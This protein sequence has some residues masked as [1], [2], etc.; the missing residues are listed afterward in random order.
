MIRVLSIHPYPSFGGPH[1]EAL[2]V[3]GYLRE[4]G[5]ET[6]LVLPEEPGTAYEQVS[7][8]MPVRRLKLGR[9]RGTLRPSVHLRTALSLGPD[10][11]RLRGLVRQERPD[12]VRVHGS[13]NPQG[14]FA[15][16]LEGVPVVWVVSNGLATV[17]RPLRAVGGMLV[18]TLAS[19][20]LLNGRL[21]AQFFPFLDLVKQRWHVYYPPVDMTRFCRFPESQLSARAE[22]GLPQD[23][24]VI[25]TIANVSPMKGIESFVDIAAL[26]RRQVPR[27][28]FVVVGAVTHPEYMR[29]LEDQ[30]K[31]LGLAD[32]VRFVGFSDQVERWL[33][34]FDVMVISS[35]TEGTTTTAGEAMASSVP[36]VAFDVGAVREIV[37][38]RKTGL[39][40]PPGDVEGAASSVLQLLSD[41]E[42][43]L[44]LEE[45]GR[46]FVHDHMS[47][48]IVA[49]QQARAIRFAVDHPRQAPRRA[50]E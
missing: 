8:R 44:Q 26:V 36:V 27:A 37:Q 11:V 10:V 42:L 15:A 4:L 48:E 25:G 13:H 31:R 24:P 47:P 6:T 9:L 33:A 45:G 7:G 50:H 12:V 19:S 49:G 39:L 43:R 3:D 34:A 38:H 17:P 14:A 28:L 5:I 22:F 40:L 23:V 35:R 30:V 16:A 1:N 41:P 18:A 46:V 20:V 2:F 29:R 32:S 21:T